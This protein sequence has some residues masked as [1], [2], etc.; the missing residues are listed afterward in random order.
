M[1]RQSSYLQ[2]Q[3]IKGWLDERKGKG[4]WVKQKISSTACW[5]T[6]ISPK[7]LLKAKQLH[8]VTEGIGNLFSFLVSSSYDRETEKTKNHRRPSLDQGGRNHLNVKKTTLIYAFCRLGRSTCGWVLIRIVNSEGHR[9]SLGSGT[10][11]TFKQTDV[12]QCSDKMILHKHENASSGRGDL[13][14]S[15][16]RIFSK[17]S[18]STWSQSSDSACFCDLAAASKEIDPTHW[19]FHPQT[20]YAQLSKEKKHYYLGQTPW[21]SRPWAAQ[22]LHLLW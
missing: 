16:G 20:Q 3:K 9:N 17:C 4:I 6:E 14:T 7:C 13:R 1:N 21:A 22:H 15:W 8:F 10:R 5:W 11:G 12:D 19:H 2:G 18:M